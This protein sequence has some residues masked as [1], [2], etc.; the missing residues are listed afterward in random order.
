M[1][2][3]S[4]EGM[5]VARV[6]ATAMLRLA[7]SQGEVDVLFEE[8]S[9]FAGLVDRDRDLASFVSSPLVDVE[10]RRQSL[11][12]LFRGRR[13]DLFVD[14]IQVMNRKGRLGLIGA[15]AE[16]YRLEREALRGR[17]EVHVQS[18]TPL[19]DSLRAKVREVAAR[20]TGKEVDLVEAVN[21]ALIGGLVLRIGDEKL[22]TSVATRLKRLGEA[23]SD[24]AAREIHSGRSYTEGAA[25]S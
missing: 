8:L 3:A 13:S 12:K 11:E 24:R 18:A 1:A 5:A 21:E 16:A 19:T 20:R 15:V 23:L 25:V 14:A 22:D 6:Y 7:E 9:D 4:D 17:V 2:S 10:V